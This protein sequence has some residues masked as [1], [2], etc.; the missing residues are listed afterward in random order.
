MFT[1][2]YRGDVHCCVYTMDG[3][4][5]NPN[6]NPNPWE[7]LSIVCRRLPLND[8]IGGEMVEKNN[9]VYPWDIAGM[10]QQRHYRGVRP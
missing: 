5:P 7:V 8:V 6:A 3:T 2:G 10:V 4:N 9:I 1:R